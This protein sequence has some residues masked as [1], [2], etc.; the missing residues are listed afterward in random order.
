MKTQYTLYKSD[1]NKGHAGKYQ[2]LE[3]G[4]CCGV[5]FSKKEAL[6]DLIKLEDEETITYVN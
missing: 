4:I 3:N 2:I 5:Y 6:K 1:K